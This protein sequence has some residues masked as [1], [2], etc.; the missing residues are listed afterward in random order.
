MSKFPEHLLKSCDL[1]DILKI[2][3]FFVSKINNRNMN[4]EFLST[5]FNSNNVE[6]V[7]RETSYNSFGTLC[8]RLN[9]LLHW[10]TISPSLNSF[11]NE[12]I[13]PCSVKCFRL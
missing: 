9:K 12:R 8:Q 1:I 4:L 2:S 5:S 6:A 13:T 11:S 7:V 10:K 3:P